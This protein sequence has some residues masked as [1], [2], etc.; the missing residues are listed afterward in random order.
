MGLPSSLLLLNAA[1]Y[2]YCQNPAAV[3][4]I[5]V[6]SRLVELSAVV[7]D[8][9][10]VPVRGLTKEDFVLKQDGGEQAIHYFSSGEDLPLTFAVLVD[11]SGSQTKFIAEETR[12][13]DAFFQ[14]MLERPND[15][16]ELVQFDQ[17]ILQLKALTNRPELLRMALLAVHSD[18]TKS[19][20]T[21]LYDAIAGVAEQ[22][23]MTAT[24]RKAIIV[25][26]DGGEQGS[27]TP[28]GYAIA[29]A[30][31]ANTPVYA[32]SYS[33]WAGADVNLQMGLGWITKEADAPDPGMG[34]LRR[35]A[36]ATGGRV[37]SVTAKMGLKEIYAQIAQDLQAQ[38]LI[39]YVP[40]ASTKTDH[41]HHLSLR[42]RQPG[43]HV[44]APNLFYAE[45]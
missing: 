30:Q 25:L 2:L 35:I 10:G 8:S 36:E 23:M 34:V 12:A 31:Q 9:H 6:K 27:R 17:E 38:Y 37:F 7:R 5:R 19:A 45:P 28:L 11:V 15:R 42:T 44:L 26:S 43:Q 14:S 40:P 16:A 39:G 24:G 4:T 21:R 3:S 32:I 29:R 20:H 18:A 41:F 33:A 1:P 13:S 22:S